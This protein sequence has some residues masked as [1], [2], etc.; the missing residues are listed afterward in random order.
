MPT[1]TLRLQYAIL[2]HAPMVFICRK[3]HPCRVMLIDW[4]LFSSEKFRQSVHVKKNPQ[5]LSRLFALLLHCTKCSQPQLNVSESRLLWRW[6]PDIYAGL[7]SSRQ[8]NVSISHGGRSFMALQ[9]FTPLSRLN[10]PNKSPKRER[11]R[12]RVTTISAL[13]WRINK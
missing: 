5:I 9:Y 12:S 8:Q 4:R 6:N 3:L 13:L 11:E 1:R 7:N 10:K 2:S